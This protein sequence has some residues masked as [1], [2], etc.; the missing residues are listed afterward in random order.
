[1]VKRQVKDDKKHDTSRNHA[2]FRLE[3]TLVAQHEDSGP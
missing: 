1:M 2:I 3:S